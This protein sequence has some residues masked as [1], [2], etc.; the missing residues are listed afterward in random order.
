[1]CAK[2]QNCRVFEVKL[3]LKLKYV[4]KWNF[5][6]HI[7]KTVSKIFLR[8]E[9]EVCTIYNIIGATKTE[10]EL[11]LKWF[12]QNWIEIKI[13]IILEVKYH[14]LLAIS[15]LLDNNCGC[16]RVTTRR[17][18]IFV[19][20]NRNIL[21]SLREIRERRDIWRPLTGLPWCELRAENSLQ[22]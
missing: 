16:Q 17:S 19:W 18:R 11:K 22:L 9:I 4:Y 5:C 14:W 21:R 6:V 10:I 1:M 7:T 8:T 13:E 20:K 2:I 15:E 3:K 12:N